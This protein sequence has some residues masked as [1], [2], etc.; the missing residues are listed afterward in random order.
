MET[1]VMYWD[2]ET[3]T[4]K[5]VITARDGSV[6][7]GT[8]KCRDADKD[9]MSEFTGGEIAERRAN[10]AY[11]RHIRDYQIKPELKGLK[12]FLKKYMSQWNLDLGEFSERNWI[13][14]AISVDLESIA[15]N[16]MWELLKNKNELKKF[17]MNESSIYRDYH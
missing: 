14:N 9:M 15:K 8:A 4:S 1:L 3:G 7:I 12:K 2:P 13:F 17:K 10:I 5:C 11:L 6:H 16:I